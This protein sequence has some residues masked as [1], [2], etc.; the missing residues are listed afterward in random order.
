LKYTGAHIELLTDIDIVNF[1]ET[2]TSGGVCQVS[3]RYSRAN[4]KYMKNYNKNLQSKY[5]YYTDVN[6][7]Y[8]TAMCMNMPISNFEWLNQSEIDSIIN[9][10]IEKLDEES[11]YGYVFDS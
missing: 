10:G 6:N 7:L 1:F 2:V 8:G 4:N 9:N 3:K 5:I 11:E